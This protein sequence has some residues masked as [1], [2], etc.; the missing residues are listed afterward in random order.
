MTTD[1]HPRN[2]T[3]EFLARLRRLIGEAQVQNFGGYWLRRWQSAKHRP[4]VDF[5]MR[6]LEQRLQMRDRAPIVRPGGWLC[7]TY[8]RHVDKRGVQDIGK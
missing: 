8:R 6:Q 4:S 3:S 2:E 5:A 1:Y 7:M